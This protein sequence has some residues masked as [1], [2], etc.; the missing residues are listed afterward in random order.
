MENKESTCHPPSFRKLYDQYAEMLR[1]FVYY[2]SGDTGFA[3]DAT[4]ESFLR[5]WKNCASVPI[6]KAKNYLFTVANNLF[7]DKVKHQKVQLKFRAIA[8]SNSTNENPEFLMEEQEFKHKLETAINALPDNQKTVFLMN[9]VDK[10][11]YREIAEALGIS[12]KA[13][14]KRIHKALLFLRTEIGNI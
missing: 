14:E 12:Q 2:K 5:L 10:M 3:E 6:E 8:Q 9:R 1:N 11:K 13:V 7:L 4:Q